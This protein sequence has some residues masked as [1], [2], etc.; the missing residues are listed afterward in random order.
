MQRAFP[1]MFHRCVRILPF[2]ELSVKLDTFTIL[3]QNPL[4]FTVPSPYDSTP[5]WVLPATRPSGRLSLA[6]PS[7][8][9]RG[10]VGVPSTFF[11]L[12]PRAV[13]SSCSIYLGPSR[14]ESHYNVAHYFLFT[15]QFR[16][17]HDACG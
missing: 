11:Y 7:L 10:E 3:R 4:T 9:P 8:T 1:W 14:L 16:L 5:V 2:Y 12:F 13:S 17:Q 6:L 15:N